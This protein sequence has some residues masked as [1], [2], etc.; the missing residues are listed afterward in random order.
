MKIVKFFIL[1]LFFA[2]QTS[3]LAA[4]SQTFLFHR[5]YMQ[6]TGK[7]SASADANYPDVLAGRL[8]ATDACG[9]ILDAVELDPNTGELSSQSTTNLSILETFQNLHA[10]F[11]EVRDFKKESD[12]T[13]MLI[14]ADV[15]TQNGPAA[16]YTNALFSRG[17]SAEDILKGTINLKP[18]RNGGTSANPH[19]FP[20]E[21]V[22][23]PNVF[24]DPSKTIFGTSLP[25]ADIGTLV[26]IKSSGVMSTP[27][28]FSGTQGTLDFGQSFGGGVLGSPSYLQQTQDFT[29]KSDGGFAMGREWS[30]SVF[31]DFLCR[32][33]PVVDPS[34]V[35]TNFFVHPASDISFRTSSACAV[36]HASIDRAAGVLRNIYYERIGGILSSNKAGITRLILEPAT[37]AAET[38][39]PSVGDA[40]Y[41][42]R[43]PS[44]RLFYRDY[45]G[46]LV[47][48][49]VSSLEDFAR[50]IRERPD[51][52]VCL[53][54]RYYEYFS[55]DKVQ[56]IYQGQTVLDAQG[57]AVRA[58]VIR[59]GEELQNTKS[60]K[61]LIKRILYD[62]NN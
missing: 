53:A 30:R 59:L 60:I 22:S 28:S 3:S 57:Q 50:N 49:P 52:Y 5:C 35:E 17:A 46:V 7:D 12:S 29:R 58:E 47:D 9:R 2:L 54:K 13:S 14:K 37:M 21:T 44:G 42:K 23:V 15:H 43:P 34:D 55:G 6:L 10:S 11:F 45:Q 20:G 51:F 56:E 18:I 26:G 8:T 48:V 24:V 4:Q 38:G 41:F 19:P 33:I 31:S 39:W 36:C 40:D 62:L 32:D 61:T 1:F 25:A 27:W 16:F